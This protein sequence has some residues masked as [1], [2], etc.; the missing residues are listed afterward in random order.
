MMLYRRVMTRLCWN[1]FFVKFIVFMA[2]TLCF[3]VAVCSA[4]PSLGPSPSQRWR[5]VPE[6]KFRSALKYGR[7]II[8]P[9]H[10]QVL[11]FITNLIPLPQYQILYL[12]TYIYS[13]AKS[14]G[15]C[16]F[17][18]KEYPAD[19]LYSG[20]SINP[21]IKTLIQK[22]HPDFNDD[23]LLGIDELIN[24]RHKYMHK[25][26]Q[27]EKKELN[28]IEAE[29]L[30]SLGKDELLSHKLK[31]RKP[32][33]P[34]FGDRIAD[35][36]ATFGG[37]WTFIIA[38]FGFLFLWMAVNVLLVIGFSEKSF[39]PYPFILLNLILSCL[40]AIQAP[41]IMMSQNRKE[42]RDRQRAE[43]DYKINLKAELEIRMLHEKLDHMIL[44]QNQRL[45]DIQEQQTDMLTD[46]LKK[47]EK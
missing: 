6:D 20:D 35:R 21:Q 28:R 10:L 5:L 3:G 15:K 11:K 22:D 41:I 4:L 1:K 23:S 36:I 37:S 25:I 12:Y 47:L 45:I 26:L 38:F 40:A 29:V 14:T 39:D 8:R 42:E 17:S 32:S 46:I 27:A 19:Q 16:C 31:N 34:S 33:P 18:N 9:Y 7:I 30:E 13:M 2:P 43:D 24:Y 44:R